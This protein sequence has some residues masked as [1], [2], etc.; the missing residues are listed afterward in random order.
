[1]SWNTSRILNDLEYEINENKQDI[2]VLEQKTLYISDQL[3]LDGTVFL[4]NVY[5]E[6]FVKNGGTASQYLMADGSTTTNSQQGQPNIYLYN[7]NNSGTPVPAS[8]QI[9]ANDPNNQNVTEL[10]ISH[11]TSDG[12]DIDVFLQQISTISVIYL[13]DRN[14]SN[15]NVR[16]NVT[17]AIIDNPNLYVTVPVIFDIAQGSGSIDFGDGHPLFMSIFDN[18]QLIDSRISA[19]ETKTQ[20][21][22][23]TS[24]ETRFNSPINMFDH[25][26]SNVA[27]PTDLNDVSTKKYVDDAVVNLNTSVNALENKTQNLNATSSGTVF[28][29]GIQFKLRDGSGDLFI[30]TN[31]ALPLQSLKFLVRQDTVQVNLPLIMGNENRIVEL[32]APVDPKDATTKSYVDT[33]DALKLNLT[34]GTLTGSITAPQFIRTGGAT[35]QFLKANG[36]VDGSTYITATNSVITDLQNKTQN[37]S[38][39]LIG[40]DFVKN[41]TVILRVADGDFFTVRNDASPVSVSKLNVSNTSV[42]INSVPLFM[43]GQRIRDIGAPVDTT[44]ATRKSYVDGLIT[45]LQTITLNQTGNSGG[46]TFQKNAEFILR[47][48]D[49][50]I[51][52]IRNDDFPSSISKLRVN[53]T[54]VQINS[55]PL[56]MNGQRIQDVGAPVDTT[57]ATTKQYVDDADALKLSLTGG[58][59]SGP[60][61][62]QSFTRTGGSPF[63]FLMANG[64]VTRPENDNG[65]RL[66]NLYYN[67]Q[68][69]LTSF[70][71]NTESWRYLSWGYI[72][73]NTV[74]TVDC[75]STLMTHQGGSLAITGINAALEPKGYKIRVSSNVSATANGATSGWL[76]AA[77]QN[78]ILPR[79]G[80][81]IKIGF[82]LDATTG[83][84][85]NRTMIG[86]FQSN[87]RPV[88]DNT[89]TIASV[90]TGSMGIVQEKGETVF[91]FNTRGPGSTKIATTI[92]CDTPNNNWY[93]LEMINEAGFPRVTL[94][95]TC[96]LPN[97]GTERATTNFI[98]GGT[99][100]M[101]LTTAWVHLQ[102]SMASPGGIN[103]SASLTLGNITMKLAQ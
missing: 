17:S 31:D 75:V 78:F 18:S 2:S 103:G 65:D 28:D 8:G 32:G 80:W 68:T 89:T 52:D 100:T 24:L 22:S 54:S 4:N 49:G 55:V 45:P 98:C 64:S 62:A 41:T 85:T 102:Q 20:H 95:L 61:E 58:V 70:S 21:Q 59:L 77:V 66:N 26:I 81:H 82:S 97:G 35:T 69:G 57:D 36:D 88:L 15:N 34:G 38:A 74:S 87:T 91:S 40:T 63:D 51:F 84:G 42:Q 30:V 14:N 60:L 92:P 13:Q 29:K 72:A 99:N 71:T 56:F 10:Y 25:K 12:I 27:D 7:N 50:D 86:L 43:Q 11:I 1:M 53:N 16:F 93:T 19:V 94:I 73:P 33:A 3:S 47:S 79:A 6:A 101:P 23:A 67:V 76:G 48:F 37:V 5:S 96:L 46:T 39:S 9:R 90:T 83:A 44:D